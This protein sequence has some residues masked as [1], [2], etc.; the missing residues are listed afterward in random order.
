MKSVVFK[1]PKK[2]TPAIMYS[3]YQEFISSR[4]TVRTFAKKYQLSEPKVEELI[5]ICKELDECFD[6]NPNIQ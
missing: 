5:K 3:L 4:H 1:I 6:D 2:M